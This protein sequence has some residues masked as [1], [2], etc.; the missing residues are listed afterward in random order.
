MAHTVMFVR[1]CVAV[2]NKCKTCHWWC[3]AFP[4]A[5]YRLFYVHS[6][7]SRPRRSS[8]GTYK[9]FVYIQLCMYLTK[10]FV[11]GT[12]LLQSILC[13][14]KCSTSSVTIESVAMSLYHIIIVRHFNHIHTYMYICTCVAVR[15]N[16]KTFQPQNFS[17]D[18]KQ[19]CNSLATDDDK[20]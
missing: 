14:V 9:Q 16:C 10:T 19:F 3:W 11:V 8:S 12:E 15:N 5:Q 2:M 18:S 7:M 20:K 1:T 6:T 17:S 13:C 4:V